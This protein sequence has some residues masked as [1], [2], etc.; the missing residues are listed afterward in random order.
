MAGK[1]CCI[2]LTISLSIFGNP[3][4]QL[5]AVDSLID[6]MSLVCEDDSEGTVVDIFK[7]SKF[8]N[9]LFQRLYQV[10]Y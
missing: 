8:P 7:P 10:R 3:E 6:S 9:P 2:V 4:D 1:I 5:S